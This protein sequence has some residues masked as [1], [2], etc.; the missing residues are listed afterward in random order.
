MIDIQLLRTDLEDVAN[1]L[2]LR[3]YDLDTAKYKELEA[4]RKDNQ[5]TTEY[6]QSQRNAKSKEIGKAKAA[7][8]QKLVDQVMAEVADF[9]EKLKQ[10]EVALAAVQKEL[11]EFLGVIPNLLHE[12]VPV[13]TTPED[14]KVERNF[15]TPR[16]FEFPVRDHVDVGE[17][18]GMLDFQTAAKLE[19]DNTEKSVCAPLYCA[20]DCQPTTAPPP[21]DG[22]TR[23]SCRSSMPCSTFP[24]AS[25]KLKLP[26]NP[27]TAA[28]CASVKLH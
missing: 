17:G 21:G 18:L 25:V 26:T 12:S 2:K 9:G 5:S 19:G 22:P 24:C 15:G 10:S 1:R 27:P 16:K 7:G 3:G 14:N 8:D 23:R 4:A 28:L 6:L 20:T 13:G 11:R